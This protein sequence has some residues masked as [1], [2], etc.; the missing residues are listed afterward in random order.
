MTWTATNR[1]KHINETS[2]QTSY[3]NPFKLSCKNMQGM[4]CNWKICF[5]VINIRTYD[6]FC[7]L[8]TKLVQLYNNRPVLTSQFDV[9]K[10]QKQLQSVIRIHLDH[11]AKF[12]PLPRNVCVTVGHNVAF[13]SMNRESDIK[14]I[15]SRQTRNWSIKTNLCQ[16]SL[17]VFV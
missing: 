8:W 2:K 7:V 17:Q 15:K 4:L 6:K 14:C 12:G 9:S 5:N 1:D 11:S 3:N 10:L 16:Q 13:N